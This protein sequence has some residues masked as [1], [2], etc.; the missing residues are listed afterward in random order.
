MAIKQHMQPLQAMFAA[1]KCLLVKSEDWKY[2]KEWHLLSSPS[3]I[4]ERYKVLTHLKP[5]A[6]YIGVKTSL[7]QYPIPGIIPT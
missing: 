7:E 1:T 5:T 4:N 2:E 3:E 6:I